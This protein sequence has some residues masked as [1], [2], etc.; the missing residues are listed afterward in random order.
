MLSHLTVSWLLKS[1]PLFW[2]CYSILTMQVLHFSH[3]LDDQDTLCCLS[4]GTSE[5]LW[6]VK[7]KRSTPLW[8]T[9]ESPVA[10]Q[11][12]NIKG[13]PNNSPGSLFKA[14]VKRTRPVILPFDQQKNCKWTSIKEYADSRQYTCT[15]RRQRKKKTDERGCFSE[16][17]GYVVCRFSQGANMLMFYKCYNEANQAP[18]CPSRLL[19]Y[20]NMC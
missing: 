17:Y 4:N 9:F 12:T 8:L 1:S 5:F 14:F 6:H 16:Y 3:I 13:N 19:G 15:N 10:R 7:F 11:L 18:D 2:I 20:P